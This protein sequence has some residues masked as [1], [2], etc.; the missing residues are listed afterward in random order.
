MKPVDCMVV[1]FVPD[2]E[3]IDY[4]AR[5]RGP[6]ITVLQIKTWTLKAERFGDETSA[7]RL[8]KWFEG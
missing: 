3:R 5:Y 4:Q 2:K 8:R 6:G 7:A 1:K